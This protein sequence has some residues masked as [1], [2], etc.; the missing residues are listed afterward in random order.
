MLTL[1]GLTRPFFG[2]IVE[3]FIG[4]MTGISRGSFAALADK[5]NFSKYDTLCD[6][7]EQPVCL[8]CSSPGNILI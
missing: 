8:L 2:W 6:G 3:Q 7:V 4:A 5:F 1:N